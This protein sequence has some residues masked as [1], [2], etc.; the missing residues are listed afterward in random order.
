MITKSTATLNLKYVLVHDLNL[1]LCYFHL[2]LPSSDCPLNRFA[3]VDE[4]ST[5]N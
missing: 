2:I 3:V 4:E 5:E 1:T